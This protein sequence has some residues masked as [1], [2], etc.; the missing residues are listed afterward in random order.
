MFVVGGSCQGPRLPCGKVLADIR[1][2]HS[3]E[4]IREEDCCRGL[5][6]DRHQQNCR[7]SDFREVA[8]FHGLQVWQYSQFDYPAVYLNEWVAQL[9]ILLVSV[10]L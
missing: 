8:G 3:V 6:R 7:E 2:V 10:L 1:I 5:G 4:I 9:I